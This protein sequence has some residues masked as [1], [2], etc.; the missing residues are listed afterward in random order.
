MSAFPT[1]TV[2]S[3]DRKMAIALTPAT[4]ALIKSPLWSLP[5]VIATPHSAGLS[6]GNAA[7]VQRMFLDNLRRWRAGEPLANLARD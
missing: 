7:R 6:D 4:R 2:N 1:R 3:D 5:N